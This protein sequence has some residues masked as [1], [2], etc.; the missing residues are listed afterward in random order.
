MAFGFFR[1]QNTFIDGCLD[2]GIV[3]RYLLETPGTEPVRAAI[4][5]ADET[6]ALVVH[7]RRDDRGAHAGVVLAIVRLFP[8]ALVCKHD[9]GSQAVRVQRKFGVNA[10]RPSDLVFF[11]GPLHEVPHRLDRK[12][13]GDLTSVVP[14]HAIGNHEQAN[15]AVDE[16]TILVEL[17]P[18]PNVWT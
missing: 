8:H 11:L 2:P 1:E 16:E 13:G 10:V 7:E 14:T 3:D 15:R 6:N 4:P 17:A 12:A 9:R 18:E 5:G